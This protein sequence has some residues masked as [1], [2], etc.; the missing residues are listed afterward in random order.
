MTS[1]S[2]QF[3]NIYGSMYRILYLKLLSANKLLVHF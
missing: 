1:L 2:V 3:A